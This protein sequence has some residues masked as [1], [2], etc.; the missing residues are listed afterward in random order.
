MLHPQ[1]AAKGRGKSPALQELCSS[2][3]QRL[4]KSSEEFWVMQEHKKHEIPKDSLAGRVVAAV[5]TVPPSRGPSVPRLEPLQGWGQERGQERGHP[6]KG[7]LLNQ[8][9]DS[10]ESPVLCVWRMPGCPEPSLPGPALCHP[11]SPSPAVS[12]L[13]A[14]HGVKPVSDIY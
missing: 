8:C 13:S 12:P 1:I 5:G 9:K 7:E 14:C 10:T 3:G 11:V 4:Q 6:A 2:A